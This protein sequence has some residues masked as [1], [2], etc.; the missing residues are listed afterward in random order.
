MSNIEVNR[1]YCNGNNLRTSL[2]DINKSFGLVDK[3]R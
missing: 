3:I 2:I 1:L